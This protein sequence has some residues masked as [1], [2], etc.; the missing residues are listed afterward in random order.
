MTEKKKS[1]LTTS[2]SSAIPALGFEKDLQ[3]EEEGDWFTLEDV[4]TRRPNLDGIV[5][6]VKVRSQHTSM[7]KNA[8]LS[9][10]MKAMRKKE[11][12]RIRFG[13][14]E[15]DRLLAEHCLVDWEIIS[16]DG[17]EVPFS[18]EAALIMM[19]DPKYRDFANFVKEAVAVIQGDVEELQE[20]AEGK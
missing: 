13:I 17:I 9:M 3:R 8:E 16:Q 12:E 1:A 19:T 4:P 7:Y 2:T 18:P 20:E 11:K 14:E 10:Q 15:V 5:R 6:R